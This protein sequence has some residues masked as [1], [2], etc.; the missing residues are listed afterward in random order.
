MITDIEFLLLG[1]AVVIAV[2]SALMLIGQ[3][4]GMVSDRGSN[5]LDPPPPMF[6]SDMPLVRFVAFYITSNFKDKMLNEVEE[7]LQ[8]NGCSFMLTAEEYLAGRIVFSM[9]AAVLTVVGSLNMSDE[10]NWLMTVFFAILG[11]MLPVVWIR[12]FKSRRNGELIKNLPVYLEYLTMCVDAGLNFAGAIKQAVDK[13]PHGA[14][15][16][17]FR[18]VLR[19]INSG[20]TRADALKRFEDRINLVDINVFVRAVIQADKLGS[21]LKDTLSAQASQRLNERFQR[22]EKLAMEA[23]VKLIV[24][25]VLFIFPLTF[26]ILFFPIAMKFIDGGF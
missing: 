22:A 26:L 5:N 25:L 24:P 21:S 14:M 10:I 8:K 19:D 16:N 23:P 2:A 11:W 6:R 20:F 12:D 4:S 18:V 17:E 13:G 15:R 1:L 9:V 3:L 7:M